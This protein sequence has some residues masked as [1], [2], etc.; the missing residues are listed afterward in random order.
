MAVVYESKIKNATVDR[1][2]EAILQLKDIDECYRFFEDL[3]TINEIKSLAQR[4]E[5][6][7]MLRN[8]ETYNEIA[9]RTG[10]STA[11]ISRVNR[12]LEYGAGG[13]QLIL[14]RLNSGQDGDA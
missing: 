12:C 14:D 11:T 4:L 3:C 6:A 9:E 8:G 7:E 2:F 10:A 13:Y 1:L 5:V